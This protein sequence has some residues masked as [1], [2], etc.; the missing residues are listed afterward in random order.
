[1]TTTSFPVS[2]AQLVVECCGDLGRL[3]AGAIDFVTPLP[4]FPILCRV[5]YGFADAT[6]T[7][8][9]VFA[10]NVDDRPCEGF[11]EG[12]FHCSDF[13][14]GRGVNFPFCSELPALP[15]LAVD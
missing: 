10:F 3:R 8:K 14:G 7:D 15:T 4:L 13:C 6:S 11:E 2:A 9:G 5:V 1:M 12:S